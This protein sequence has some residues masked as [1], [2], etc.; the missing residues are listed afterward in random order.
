MWLSEFKLGQGRCMVY[1]H[2]GS[3]VNSA[4][5]GHMKMLQSQVDRCKPNLAV[6]VVEY[7][8]ATKEHYPFQLQQAVSAIHHL[9]R[10]KQIKP[11]EIILAGDSAGGNLV[12]AVLLHS[13]LPH[14]TVTPLDLGEDAFAVAFLISPWVTFD[15]NVL[16]TRNLYGDYINPKALS[17]AALDFTNGKEDCY[18]TPLKASSV[19]WKGIRTKDTA[20][21]AGEHELMLNDIVHFADNLKLYIAANEAHVQMVLN[22]TLN[23]AK[24]ESEKY[25]ERWLDEELQR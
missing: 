4:Y 21:I 11:S 3:Y 14:P 15:V 2:G 16:E 9:L 8:L 22:R 10:V 12:A 19:L 17:R 13:S 6:A 7:T 23:L 20:I 1:F 5:P 24:S 18:S 25:F